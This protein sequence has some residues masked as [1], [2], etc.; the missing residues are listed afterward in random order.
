[1][2]PPKVPALAERI[3]GEGAIPP[4]PPVQG[5][6]APV[7]PAPVAKAETVGV[8][9]GTG[10]TSYD[11]GRTTRRMRMRREELAKAELAAFRRFERSRQA[12]WCVAG[13]PVH[14]R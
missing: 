5:E 6:S 13:F 14:R 4:P 10:I 7:T 3:Y 9:S 1:M 8:T 11:L 12:C 2:P